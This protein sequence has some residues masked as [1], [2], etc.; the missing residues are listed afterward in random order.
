MLKLRPSASPI[1]SKCP[2]SVKAQAGYE[3]ESGP[4]ALEGTVAHSILECC[5][6]NGEAEADGYIGT[7]VTE[8]AP[9]LE[10]EKHGDF[11]RD[12]KGDWKK[13]DREMAHGVNLFLDYA[14]SRGHSWFA[15]ER[16]VYA[17]HID[18]TLDGTA[19]YIGYN[20]ENGVLD[21]V[22][23]KFGYVVVECSSPQLLSYGIGASRVEDLSGWKKLRMTI[24]QPRASH[25]D[26]PV[27]TRELDRVELFEESM[28]LKA[29]AAATRADDA[30]FVPGKHCRYCKH[31]PF[32]KVL[33]SAVRDTVVN[34]DPQEADE[35]AQAYRNAPMVEAWLKAVKSRAESK[36]KAGPLRH[37]KWVRGRGQRG[38]KGDAANGRY[39]LDIST[40]LMVPVDVISKRELL[41]PAQ[42]EKTVTKAQFA[43]V[44][45]EID[46]KPGS[47]KLVLE[48]EPGDS[49][50][51][52][53]GLTG[54]AGFA[55]IKG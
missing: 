30:P 41:S 40:K 23:F 10:L 52:G 19:D 53:G 6:K 1:W 31:A 13:I 34:N 26:G 14:F 16:R 46:K 39:A 37:F 50:P 7:L 51:Y 35:L 47:L 4:E 45:D 12:E 9:I 32:C 36:A 8:W 54:G 3:D 17:H 49:V 44:Q 43:R 48:S 15:S 5:L 25:P 24:V 42:L 21:I 18:P 22:D 55:P 38:W 2:A 29:Q 27:R 11:F 33:S 28:Q 20:A